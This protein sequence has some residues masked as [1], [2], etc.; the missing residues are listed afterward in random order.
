MPFLQFK[1]GRR[2]RE[3]IFRATAIAPSSPS[4][5][6]KLKSWRATFPLFCRSLGLKPLR[7]SNFPSSFRLIKI[8]CWGAARDVDKKL[9]SGGLQTDGSYELN[10]RRCL[11]AGI[12]FLAGEFKYIA[13]AKKP[14]R[15]PGAA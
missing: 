12:N 9:Y 1:T 10:D 5:T 3:K 4:L 7:A 11:P 13:A 2:T 6:G 15:F 8:F 14:P